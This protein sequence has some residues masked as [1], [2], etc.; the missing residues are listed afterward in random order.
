MKNQDHVEESDDEDA[1]KE[2]GAGPSEADA[3]A[4]EERAKKEKEAK[5]EELR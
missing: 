4:E 5:D 2:E 1:K 3:K